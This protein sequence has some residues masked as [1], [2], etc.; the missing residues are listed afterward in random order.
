MVVI[1]DEELLYALWENK[2]V[3]FKL[4]REEDTKFLRWEKRNLEN[5]ENTKTDI[6]DTNDTT[7][8]VLTLDPLDWQ[9]LKAI[10]NNTLKSEVI[11]KIVGVSA[12][13]VRR[14]YRKLKEMGLIRVIS[15]Q[16]ARLTSV[17][18]A[19]IDTTR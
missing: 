11:A 1:L 19:L 12:I 14:R 8:I 2:P 4:R 15:N 16:G 13:T 17:G 7:T 9:I 18:K 6:D 3:W 10:G 5:F